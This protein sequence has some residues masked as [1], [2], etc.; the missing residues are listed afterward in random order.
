[1]VATKAMALSE[2][3]SSVEFEQVYG[4]HCDEG[5]WAFMY[6]VWHEH[7][8]WDLSFLWNVAREMIAEFNAPQK[9]PLN[10][11]PA[12]FVPLADQTL[13]VADQPSQAINEDSPAVN[14][15]GGG[16]VHE[17]D[18]LVQIDNPA[19]VLSSEDHPPSRLN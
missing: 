12:E 15:D 16:G 2:Y 3:Q 11:P 5:I 7:P 4:E 19:G 14:A 6:N 10:D 17:D 13:Q 9:T 18:E 8:E 1:M